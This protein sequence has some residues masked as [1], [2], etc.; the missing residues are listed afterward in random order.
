MEDVE[1]IVLSDYNRGYLEMAIDCEGNLSLTKDK[2][3]TAKRGYTWRPR[4]MVTNTNLK[5]LEALKDISGGL[6]KIILSR[7]QKGN[8]KAVYY[9]YLRPSE[10][11][12]ILPQLSLTIKE[13]QRILLLD[14]L[15]LLEENRYSSSR[16]SKN[17]AG[18][19]QIYLDLKKLNGKGVHQ[20]YL[21]FIGK[22]RC[23]ER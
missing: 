19:E 23:K 8:Y 9:W 4:V 18:L 7:G 13:E 11:R 2:S 21:P 17:D 20:S 3:D 5:L 16:S 15:L 6:G 14:A 1:P 12:V 22:R 10:Q